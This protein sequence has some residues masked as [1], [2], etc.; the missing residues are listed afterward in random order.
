M[1]AANAF[2]Q[3]AAKA[4]TQQFEQKE[5]QKLQNIN[6]L[7]QY[8][9]Q[10]YPTLTPDGQKQ[11]MALYS[12][13]IG[14]E[15]LGAIDSKGKDKGADKQQGIGVH[16][17][18]ALKDLATGMVGGKLPK[19]APDVD[20]N[21]V[22]GQLALISSNPK[23]TREGAISENTKQIEAKLN[24]F[25]GNQEE[26]MRL[27]APH[28]QAISGLDPERA[29]AA[30]EN[31][32]GGYQPAPA[33]G[34]PEWYA[35]QQR[36]QPTSKDLA[37]PP[38]PDE[39]PDLGSYGNLKY[40]GPAQRVNLSNPANPSQQISATLDA[41]TNIYK[42]PNT[43]IPLP[44]A[45]QGWLKETTPYHP[46]QT[47]K[48]IAEKVRSDD[49]KRWVDVFQT[50]DGSKYE[51]EV[52]TTPPRSPDAWKSRFVATQAA[53]DARDFS[54]ATQQI[55]Q[56][57]I[58]EKVSINRTFDAQIAKVKGD[59]LQ[60]K[61]ADATLKGIEQ[62]RQQRLSELEE[63]TQNAKAA[64]GSSSPG[65]N[66][67]PKPPPGPPSKKAPVTPQAKSVLPWG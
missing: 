11:A 50:A 13:A 20:T 61:T 10:V 56:K 18:N 14:Q 47:D 12:R 25:S 39:P 26:A 43:G 29:K 4:R 19:G 9:T 23:F 27:I 46:P 17:T 24:G 7:N 59:P 31:Y 15:T 35:E 36:K 67:S 51:K 66:D 21:S 8:M 64:I 57:Y 62:E 1:M 58:S 41:R 32:L 63:D 48:K 3:S 28:L 2:I 16:F 65:R 49:G 38:G 45:Q 44:Q 5:N 52:Y 60:A 6:R 37:S 54:K 22:I 30:R 53:I 55:N 33:Q 42:D 40:Y 34:T